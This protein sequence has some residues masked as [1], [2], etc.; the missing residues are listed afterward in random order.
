MGC[1]QWATQQA[2][3]LG[4]D[5]EAAEREKEGREVSSR[6]RER[7]RER[8]RVRIRREEVW[9]RKENKSQGETRAGGRETP[10]ETNGDKLRET[11]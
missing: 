11:A 2:E 5:R 7:K 10:G 9:V 4:G 6:K 3:E 1:G 8:C